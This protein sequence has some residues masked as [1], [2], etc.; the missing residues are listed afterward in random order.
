MGVCFIFHHIW[1]SS[2]CSS[3]G[4]LFQMLLTLIIII[5]VIIMI[6]VMWVEILWQIGN[7]ILYI[8][9]Y[10]CVFCVYLLTFFFFSDKNDN[11]LIYIYIFINI[12][13]EYTYKYTFIILFISLFDRNCLKMC[14]NIVKK[15][16]SI[17][18]Q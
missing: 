8:S 12:Y 18:I 10:V 2:L 3:F 16:T 17:A 4:C 13:V 9:Y 1:Y 6:C 11:C 14:K 15:I 7:K 5:S